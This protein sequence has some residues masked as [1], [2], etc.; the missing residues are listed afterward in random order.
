MDLDLV[1]VRVFGDVLAGTFQTSTQSVSPFGGAIAGLLPLVDTLSFFARYE[2]LNKHPL[3]GNLVDRIQ[4]GPMF[5]WGDRLQ[6]YLL[7][8]NYRDGMDGSRDI[9]ETRVRLSIL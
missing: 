3:S 4:V 9:F 6:I 2:T 5:Y 7:Y 8:A 1:F